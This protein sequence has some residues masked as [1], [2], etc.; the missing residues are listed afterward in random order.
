MIL[1]SDS[2]FFEALMTN[3]MRETSQ[4]EMIIGVK[5]AREAELLARLLRFLYTG[6]LSSSGGVSSNADSKSPLA[7]ND[8][9]ALLLLADK[10]RIDTAVAAAAQQLC[11]KLSVEAALAYLNLPETLT[12]SDAGEGLVGKCKACI[13]M[14]FKVSPCLD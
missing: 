5:D 4:K 12:A 13:A 14:Q 3:G 2:R 11:N 7:E 8:M 9:L 6:D 1:A 10:F